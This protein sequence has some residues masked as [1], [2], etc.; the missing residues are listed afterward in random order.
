MLLRKS[1]LNVFMFVVGISNS[2]NRVTPKIWAIKLFVCAFHHFLK[3]LQSIPPVKSIWHSTFWELLNLSLNTFVS[4]KKNMIEDFFPC[5]KHKW[6]FVTKIVLTYCE[7]KLFYWSRKTFEIW[8]W[9]TK[10]AEKSENEF[11]LTEGQNNFGNKIPCTNFIKC[12]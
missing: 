4:M 1:E 9:R 2:P 7:K 12:S 6:Y 5:S 8:G 3:L 11:F 10:K